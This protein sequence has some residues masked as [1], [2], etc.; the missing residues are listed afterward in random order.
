MTIDR[1]E[2]GKGYTKENCRLI[3]NWANISI[4]DWGDEIF[5]DMV[6]SAATALRNRKTAD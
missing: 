6:R 2:N 1:I 5:E 3:C 4:N